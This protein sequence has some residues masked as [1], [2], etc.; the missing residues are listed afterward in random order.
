[1]WIAAM[2]PSEPGRCLV[3]LLPI[4]EGSEIERIKLL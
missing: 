2:M 4:D 1:M 3:H